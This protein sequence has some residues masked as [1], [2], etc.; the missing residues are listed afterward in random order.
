MM[1]A[2]DLLQV[3]VCEELQAFCMSLIL[4]VAQLCICTECKKEGHLM[5]TSWIVLEN[6]QVFLNDEP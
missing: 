6:M 1:I 4:L 5:W 3:E 2:K